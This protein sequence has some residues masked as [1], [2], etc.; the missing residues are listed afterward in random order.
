VENVIAQLKNFRI[1]SYRYRNKR[2]GYNL[3]FNI[4]GGLVNLKQ[5]FLSQGL[6]A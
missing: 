1:L 6:A 2:K 5:G 3:K 4:I